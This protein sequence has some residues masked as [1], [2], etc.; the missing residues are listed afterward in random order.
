[1]CYTLYS[2]TVRSRNPKA[3]GCS[4]DIRDTVTISIRGFIVTVTMQFTNMA[5]GSCH[6]TVHTSS[7]YSCVRVCCTLARVHASVPQSRARTYL[8]VL[9]VTRV[10]TRVVPQQL[11]CTRQITRWFRPHM[12]YRTSELYCSLHVHVCSF[13]L[14]NASGWSWRVSMLDNSYT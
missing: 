14:T 4:I 2:G 1:M 9:H 7:A 12:C 8:R 6:C 3:L 13:S 5:H 10:S 11:A